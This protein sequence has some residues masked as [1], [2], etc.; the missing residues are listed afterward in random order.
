MKTTLFSIVLVTAIFLCISCSS[1]ETPNTTDDD[2]STSTANLIIKLD[3]DPSQARLGNTGQPTE[4]PSG[5]AGQDPNF[6][7]ISAHYLE[8]SPSA[9]TLLGQG[10]V[11]YKAPETE[12]GGNLA[13]DFE[14][15]IV[16]TP[17]EVF[18]TI[19]LDEIATG[20]Y[21]W[22]RLSLSYQNYDIDFAFN[23]LPLTGTVASFVG[24]DTYLQSYTIKNEV[25]TVNE[26]RRQGYW[27]FETNGIVQ[28]GLAPEGATTVPNPLFD[29][30][31][32]PAGSCVVTGKFTSN[33]VITGDETEDITVTLSLS[34]NKSFEWIDTNGNNTWDVTTSGAESIVDMGLRGL[35]PSHNN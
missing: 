3:V 32:I 11:L 14:Q 30:S 15:A 10:A 19:P 25:V 7:T 1:D 8:L 33:L 20:N 22:V 35:V 12:S 28:T 23:G 16:V 5:H 27:G 9:T 29:S 6:N 24:F 2:A 13:I 34:T 31:P 4:I 17:G 26:N 21:E 18:L